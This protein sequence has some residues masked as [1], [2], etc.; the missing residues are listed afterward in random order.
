MNKEIDLGGG[1]RAEMRVDL[2]GGD[3]KRYLIRRDEMM[4]ENGTA[5][6][7]ESRP[8]PANPAV[9]LDIPAVP[10][11]LTVADNIALLDH[12]LANLLVSWTLPEQLPWTEDFRETMDLDVVNAL[13][14]AAM[15]VSRYIMGTGPKPTKTLPTSGDTSS[16]NA[17]ASPEEPEATTS[18]T[19]SGS[20][21]DGSTP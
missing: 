19:P 8:D 6:P 1:N 16:G 14:A 12:V 4:R 2:T 9:M 20:S 11:Y 17:A 10:A 15:S 3:Q 18:G 13:D 7:A 21:E 5:K